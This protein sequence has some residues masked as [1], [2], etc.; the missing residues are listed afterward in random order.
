MYEDQSNMTQAFQYERTQQ[1]GQHITILD[2]SAQPREFNLTSFH[3]TEVTFGRANSGEHSDIELMSKIVSRQHGKFV[4][5]NGQWYIVDTGSANGILHNNRYIAKRALTEGSIY[6][7]DLRTEE[8]SDSVLIVVSSNQMDIR[9][10][11]YPIEKNRITIGR[12]S[13]CDVF[14]PHVSVSRMHAFIQK[15]NRGW[16]IQDANSANGTLQNGAQLKT[17]AMLHEKDVITIANTKIIFTSS[18]LFVCTYNHGISVEARNIVVRRGKGDKSFITSDHVNLEIKPGELVSIIGG[19]GA[20]KSTIMNVLCGYLSPTEGDVHINGVNL[21]KNFSSLKKLFGYVPQQDI[22]YN[23]LTLYDMLK[24]TAKLRLPPDTDERDRNQ[25]IN[26][27]I[28]MVDLED[29]RDSLIKALSGGQKKRASIAVE[30]LSDPKLL[31]LDEPSSGLDPGT[32]RSLM[33]S[34]RRMADAGKTIILVT[35]STLQLS[36]CDKIAF[37]GKGG[38]LC[39]FG[40]VNEAKAFFGVND[41]VDIYAKITN[42]PLEW[43]TKY[44]HTHLS[45]HKT[46]E[47]P[48]PGT[49]NAKDKTSLKQMSVLCKRYTKLVWNDRQRLILL[50]VQAPLLAALISLVAN[51][52][53]FKQYEMSKSLLFALSCSGFWVGMLNAIQE[54]CKERTILKREYMTGLSLSYYVLSKI[55]VLSVLC[56]IQSIMLTS[57]FSLMVGLPENGVIFSPII[58]MFITTW[59]TSTSAAATGLF[60]SSLFTNPDRA[61]TVAPL[62]LMPQMLFSGLLFKLSDGTEII[63]WF[64]ICR[65]SMEGYGSTADLN[66]LPTAL[67]QQGFQILD[68]AEKFYEVSSSHMVK[69]W[70]IMIAMAI[71]YLFLARRILSKIRKESS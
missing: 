17:A 64:A 36:L 41:V 31:F 60:V 12:D 22:V 47:Q 51:G 63:S 42:A 5:E 59:I 1:S 56:L 9:W 14:L 35:H 43:R 61:M 13:R 69:T 53:Q 29:K 50:M 38:N 21:Y 45:L 70:V 71:L 10:V 6:H 62:L 32:E 37:M 48:L 8:R 23:N 46:E 16:M 33:L 49:A 11:R 68:E 25:A 26:K 19:S 58:E 44:E 4:F 66:S 3:K 54:I 7:I 39:F 57:V 55:I 30:L 67:Q 15:T 20:G 18:A 2:G 28:A 27:A 34:L 65:W 40:N 24:Y 52:Q